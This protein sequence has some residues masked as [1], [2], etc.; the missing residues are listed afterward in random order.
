MTQRNVIAY[1]MSAAW[2]A[3]RVRFVAS[4]AE[5]LAK[6]GGPVSFVGLGILVDAIV[7]RDR[8]TAF[9]GM[10]ILVAAQT[11][12]ATANQFGLR[13]RLALAERTGAVID[14]QVVQA[15]QRLP[16][17][18]VESDDELKD[19]L[20]RI[21]DNQGALAGAMN[22][23]LNTTAVCALSGGVILT[24]V[25][26]HPAMLLLLPFSLPTLLLAR[27]E[28]RVTATADAALSRQDRIADK[29]MEYT[30]R[31]GENGELRLF[32]AGSTAMKVHDS[33]NEAAMGVVTSFEQKV[34][35]MRWIRDGVFLVGYAFAT[36]GLVLLTMWGNISPGQAII[37]ILVSRLVHSQVLAPLDTIS[38]LTRILNT[39]RDA[40]TVI[41]RASRCAPVE[42]Q[43]PSVRENGI[44]AINV[45]Y[46]YR[47]ESREALRSVT[48]KE[49]AGTAVA[50]LGENG[51]GKSTL[52]KLLLGLYAPTSGR[53]ESSVTQVSHSSVTFQDF[54][55]FEFTL[56]ECVGV[57]D[58]QLLSSSMHIRSAL[59]TVSGED[60]SHKSPRELDV[61]LGSSWDNGIDL[62]GG[63]WQKTALARMAMRPASLVVWD[64]PTSAMDAYAEDQMYETFNTVFDDVRAR[65]GIAFL[66]THRVSGAMLADKCIV[67][68]DGA[69]EESGSHAE[70]MA[71]DGQYARLVHSERVAFEPSDKA[72]RRG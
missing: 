24:L 48:L 19:T 5:P 42:C 18:E 59:A 20:A 17:S 50:I 37:G 10:T 63:E 1:V 40:L 70:L 6:L 36:I 44:A 33:A 15:I 54:A 53:I 11:L 58:L 64:E 61:Q 27:S 55:R 32:S 22:M 25:I 45:T 39:A 2:R 47:G 52:M 67:L 26:I 8:S 56:G 9:V 41:S 65:G 31:S 46:R 12:I 3:S 43:T 7:N 38:F 62:S 60:L 34:M 28:R 72:T 51:S 69:I 29:V 16:L 57:G 13:T 14:R 66:V 21:R 30:L 68:Q 23:I 35:R 49:E 4:L 71:R